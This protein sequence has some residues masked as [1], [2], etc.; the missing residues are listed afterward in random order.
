MALYELKIL[1]SSS[2]KHQVLPI[3]RELSVFRRLCDPFN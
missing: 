3:L 2:S 1:F